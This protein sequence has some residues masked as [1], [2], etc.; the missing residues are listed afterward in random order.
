M[1]PSI[2]L[3]INCAFFFQQ[4]FGIRNVE[5]KKREGANPTKRERVKD[6][7]SKSIVK[8]GETERE[9]YSAKPLNLTVSLS[10]ILID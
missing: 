5:E 2:S 6:N 4:Q 1:K 10:Y 8:N 7:K 3:S 9:V